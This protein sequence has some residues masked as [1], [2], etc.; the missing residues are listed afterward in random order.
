MFPESESYTHVYDAAG[1][2]RTGK[3]LM[4]HGIYLGDDDLE[5]VTRSGT[6]LVH[7]PDS[8]LNLASGIMDVTGLM[9]RGLAAGPGLR[10]GRSGHELPMNRVLV[11]AVQSS[12]TRKHFLGEGR[13]LTHEQAFYLATRGGEPIWENT[14]RFD[15]GMPLRRSGSR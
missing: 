7:C 4:A 10:C 13:E 5:R 8:N 12:K 2:L 14:G 15:K 6:I 11:S 1:L 3:T 9:D